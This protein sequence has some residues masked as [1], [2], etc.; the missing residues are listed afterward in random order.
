MIL[1]M[2]APLVILPANIAMV[3]PL[4]RVIPVMTGIY[5][6]DFNAQFVVL[7]VRLAQVQ[8]QINV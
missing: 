8:H 6:V 3:R 5:I 1:L 7:L 2:V 4:Q